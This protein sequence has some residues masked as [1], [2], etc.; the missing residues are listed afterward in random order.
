M[1]DRP[2]LPPLPPNDPDREGFD[3][4]YFQARVKAREQYERGGY[5]GQQREVK[6]KTQIQLWYRDLAITRKQKQESESK[7]Q[8][9]HERQSD[10]RPT[11]E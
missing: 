4:K 5:Q 3:L 8:T 11:D 2:D 1:T 10:Q 9:D 6:G 7:E